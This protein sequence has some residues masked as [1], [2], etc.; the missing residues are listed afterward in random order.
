MEVHIQDLENDSKEMH[1]R[2]NTKILMINSLYKW[3]IYFNSVCLYK[4]ARHLDLLLEN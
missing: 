2:W 3:Y 1:E 4:F